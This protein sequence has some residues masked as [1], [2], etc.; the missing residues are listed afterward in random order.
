MDMKK[1]RITKNVEDGLSLRFI[2]VLLIL[3][4]LP[5]T[6]LF[7]SILGNN[8]LEKKE[9]N[10]AIEF[11]VDS[12]SITPALRSNLYNKNGE[13]FNLKSYTFFKRHKIQKGD[14]LIKEAGSME[15]YIY[16]YSDKGEKQ[17]HLKLN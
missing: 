11:K 15:L 8:Y 14:L 10:V 16:R 4:V 6:I 17:L 12:I 5:V 7:I 13:K 9:L 3:V 2:K 1:S